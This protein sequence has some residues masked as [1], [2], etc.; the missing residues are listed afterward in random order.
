MDVADSCLDE[1]RGQS[2]AVIAFFRVLVNLNGTL[3]VRNQVP[4][5]NAQALAKDGLESVVN[6]AA[7]RA[8]L[9]K[10]SVEEDVLPCVRLLQ[11]SK[12]DMHG[13]V[14][15]ARLGIVDNTLG[16]IENTSRLHDKG[17]AVHVIEVVA[18]VRGAACKK[19]NEQC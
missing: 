7:V 1:I 6:G 17:L 19:V 16:H 11:K 13:H 2:G 18:C 15:S 8:A 12:R 5:G 4:P 3:P 10:A 14:A 9:F